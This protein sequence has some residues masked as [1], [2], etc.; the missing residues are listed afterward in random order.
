M[1]RKQD[2]RG[3]ALHHATV[4]DV[5]LMV[6]RDCKEAWRRLQLTLN[7]ELTGIIVLLWD[8]IPVV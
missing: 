5:S 4:T 7:H 2:N 6:P 3:G 1:I 8:R